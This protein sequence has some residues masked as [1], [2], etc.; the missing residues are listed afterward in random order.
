MARRLGREGSV[1]LGIVIGSN[2][3]VAAASVIGSSGHSR[4]DEAARNWVVAHWRYQPATR[5]GKPIAS[6]EKVKIVFKLS[7]AY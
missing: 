7:Q 6:R 2:G 1:L 5:N 4:L 3:H